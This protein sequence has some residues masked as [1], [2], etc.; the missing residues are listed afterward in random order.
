MT[1][2]NDV[3]FLDCGAFGEAGGAGGGDVDADGRAVED[4]L[5]HAAADGGALHEAVAAEAGGNRQSFRAASPAEEGVV[6]GGDLVEAG[7]AAE[8]VGLGEGWSPGEEGLD[9]A[10]QPTLVDGLVGAAGFVAVGHT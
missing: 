2:S 4:Q 8:D 3:M 5:S 1:P 10:G 9:G 7:P 6:V